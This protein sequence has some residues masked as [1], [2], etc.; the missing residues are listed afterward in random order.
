MTNGQN[1][2]N[3]KLRG[4]KT[5]SLLAKDVITFLSNY[6]N[7]NV[8]AIYLCDDSECSLS[9]FGKYGFISEDRSSEKFALNE[10]LIGQ[11]AAEQKKSF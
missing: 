2:L 7:A 10:G 11:V 8:G 5:E 6:L 4:D 3:E 9:V 1:F